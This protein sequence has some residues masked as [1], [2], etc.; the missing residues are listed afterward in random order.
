MEVVGPPIAA[1]MMDHMGDWLPY[2]LSL[3]LWAVACICALAMPETL[4]QSAN[5]QD[6]PIAELEDGTVLYPVNSKS[7]LG[8]RLAGYKQSAIASFAFFG[9]NVQV[10]LL[11]F[12][13]ALSAFGKQSVFQLLLLYASKRL[14][15]S[16]AQV[17]L[18]LLHRFL[19][20]T[21]S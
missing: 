17:C 12:M 1:I 2:M 18:R 14:D 6:A 19:K 7:G 4:D 5:D 8:D 20:R 10:Q 15:L 9:H 13:L 3:V 11:V 16:I 21:S